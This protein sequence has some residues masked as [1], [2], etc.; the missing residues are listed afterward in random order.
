MSVLRLRKSLYKMIDYNN[1]DLTVN[2]DQFSNLS[3]KKGICLYVYTKFLRRLIR[4]KHQNGNKE[5][6]KFY[7]KDNINEVYKNCERFLNEH[8]EDKTLINKLQEFYD[9][10]KNWN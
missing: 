7:N 9:K 4:A 10:L 2:N 3:I 1:I 5:T 8:C 6:K